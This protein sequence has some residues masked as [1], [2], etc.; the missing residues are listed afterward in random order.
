MAA[1]RSQGNRGDKEFRPLPGLA[2][3]VGEG[4]RAFTEFEDGDVRFGPNF[5]R[6]NQVRPALS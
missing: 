6:A 1:A 5:E 2:H 3:G 4:D